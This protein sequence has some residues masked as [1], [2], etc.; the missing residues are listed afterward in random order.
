MRVKSYLITCLFVAVCLLIGIVCFDVYTDAFSGLTTALVSV[1]AFG[2]LLQFAI[3]HN[4]WDCSVTG[5]DGLS[6]RIAE[7]ILIGP[8]IVVF[9]YTYLVKSSPILRVSLVIGVIVILLI[10][11]IPLILRYRKHINDG[12]EVK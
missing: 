5:A 11:L 4:K 1:Y 6:V 12:Q 9:L 3:L 8:A 7:I 2:T 10:A